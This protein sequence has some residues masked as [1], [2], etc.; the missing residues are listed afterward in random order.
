M[1]E[2]PKEWARYRMSIISDDEFFSRTSSKEF[3][4][5]FHKKL[6]HIV[7][8]GRLIFKLVPK[9]NPSDPPPPT[10]SPP[11]PPPRSSLWSARQAGVLS[12]KLKPF[13]KLIM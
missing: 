10:L 6:N 4:M 7:E 1:K 12:V 11:H 13:T 2:G 9:F 3:S 5:G 8:V